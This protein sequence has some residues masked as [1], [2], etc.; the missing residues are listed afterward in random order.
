MDC[1]S[2]RMSDLMTWN[3]FQERIVKSKQPQVAICVIIG[4]ADT[5]AIRSY[6]STFD[7]RFRLYIDTCAQFLRLNGFI[8]EEE[9]YRTFLLDEH[10]RITLIGRPFLSPESEALFNRKIHRLWK[11]QSKNK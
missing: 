11:K 2:C 9:V 5:A 6:A 4:T 8:P 10:N 1:T 3:L 7:Y